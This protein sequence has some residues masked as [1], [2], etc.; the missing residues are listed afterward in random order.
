LKRWIRGFKKTWLRSTIALIY[1]LLGI[2]CCGM[3]TW[4]AI[5]GLIDVFG[6]GGTVAVSFGCPVPV[7]LM[8]ERTGKALRG[9]A[10]EALVKL[11]ST[12]PR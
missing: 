12:K 6:P 9:G 1:V 10:V 5:A 7:Y 8:Q 11:G 4:A 2:A 3:G